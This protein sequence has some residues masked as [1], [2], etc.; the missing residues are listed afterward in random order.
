MSHGLPRPGIGRLAVKIF[1]VALVAVAVLAAAV[2][3]VHLMLAPEP[4]RPA[5]DAVS[6][7]W[8]AFTSQQRERYQRLGLACRLLATEPSLREVL[9]AAGGAEADDEEAARGSA[10]LTDL[11][12]QRRDELHYEI[13]LVLDSE[14]RVVAASDM[15]GLL[16]QDLSALPLVA[17]ALEEGTA[18][19]VWR[20]DDGSL[21]HA[22]VEWVAPDF[23]LLGYVVTGL[24]IDE[25]LA[26]EVQRTSGSGTAFVTTDGGGLRAVGSSFDAAAAEGLAAYLAAPQAGVEA[27]LASGDTREGVELPLGERLYEALLAPLRDAHGDAVGAVVIAAPLAVE[28]VDPLP[29]A[30]AA[31]AAAAL[32][33]AFVAALLLARATLSPVGRFSELVRAAP[34][35]GFARRP[36]A[37]RAGHLAPLAGAL[38]ALFRNLQEE[39]AL[40]AAVAAGES[41]GGGGAAATDGDESGEEKVTLLAVDLRRFARLG[42]ATGSAREAVERLHRDVARTRSLV[43]ARGGRLAAAA[44]HR[45]LAVFAGDAAD[46]AAVEAG[47]AVLGALAEPDSAFDEGEPPALAVA[48]GRV[49]A[50]SEAGGA[51]VLLGPAVQLAEGLLREAAAGDLVLARP[52]HKTV[53]ERLEARGVAASEQRGFLSPQPLFV[54]DAAAAAALA[55]G[56]GAAGSDTAADAPAAA[57]DVVEERFEVVEVVAAGRPDDLRGDLRGDLLRARDRELGEVVALR[58]LAPSAVEV[59]ALSGL[60]SPLGGVRRFAHPAVATLFDFGESSRG[61]VFLS[62]E[63]VPG[64]ALPRLSDLP[65]PAALGLGRQLAAALAAIHAHGLFHGRV[66]PENV[67]TVP[68]GVVRLTDLGVALAAGPGSSTSAGD[69][70]LAPEQRGGDRGDARS[71]VFA[72]GALLARL[73]AGRWWS[74][75]GAALAGD[76]EGNLPAGLEE[77]LRRC[78]EVDPAARWADGGDLLRALEDVSA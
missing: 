20:R 67:I 37:D 28:A 45:L 16:G 32:L 48:R 38:A 34:R 8:A 55:A 5:V 74:G 2:L 51:E 18:R 46:W 68:G 41:A 42:S 23:D 27:V 33:L 44:G 78:L 60:E 35:E 39:R 47:A 14:A 54:L 4:D 66:K 21:V 13:A 36:D 40:A 43:A 29:L 12:L 76:D 64:V 75:E 19:G 69:R 3:T 56:G 10:A 24:V 62:R 22:A 11:L 59:A 72:A 1:V 71:D 63:W 6:R 49:A 58:R 53:A 9:R 26:L 57:G 15:P 25:V 73:V 50:A 17:R 31:G 65:L 30:L 52:V 77:I 70:L 7:G 61:G